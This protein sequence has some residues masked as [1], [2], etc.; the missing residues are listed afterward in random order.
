MALRRAYKLL[1]RK[2]NKLDEALAEMEKE[3]EQFKAVQTMID[4]AK[5]SSRGLIR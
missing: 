2:G 3:A 5:S 4:F 1:Y